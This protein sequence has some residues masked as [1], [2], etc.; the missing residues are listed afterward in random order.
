MALDLRDAAIDA[1]I[2]ARCVVALPLL[3]QTRDAGLDPLVLVGFALPGQ[4]GPNRLHD[5]VV[6]RLQLRVIVLDG[7][8]E[9]AEVGVRVVV[10]QLVVDL[11]DRQV[12]QTDVGRLQRHHRLLVGAVELRVEVG[13]QRL[14]LLIEP[15]RVLD[16]GGHHDLVRRVGQGVGKVVQVDLQAQI[17][18]GEA[19]LRSLLDVAEAELPVI[20]RGHLARGRQPGD[21]GLAENLAHHVGVE[22]IAA[23]IGQHRLDA[24]QALLHDRIGCDHRHRSLGSIHGNRRR[25]GHGRGQRGVRALLSIRAGLVEDRIVGGQFIVVA[26]IGLAAIAEEVGL[27]PVGLTGIAGAIFGTLAEIVAVAIVI[28]GIKGPRLLQVRGA[29]I[30]AGIRRGSAQRLTGVIAEAR[31]RQ[32]REGLHQIGDQGLL[33]RVIALGQAL[34]QAGHVHLAGFGQTGRAVGAVVDLVV[35]VP[36]DLAHRADQR[37]GNDLFELDDPLGHAHGV[38]EEIL[39]QTA[40]LD[41]D[42]GLARRDLEDLQATGL[43]VL[44]DHAPGVRRLDEDLVLLHARQGIGVGDDR[45]HILV[46]EL[47]VDDRL[48]V[49]GD[50]RRDERALVLLVAAPGLLAQAAELAAGRQDQ[51]DVGVGVEFDVAVGVEDL[52]GIG[53]DERHIVTQRVDGRARL[54]LAEHGAQALLRAE[55]LGRGGRRGFRRNARGDDLVDLAGVRADGLPVGRIGR[56]IRL[57]ERIAHGCSYLARRGGFFR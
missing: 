1:P 34:D 54:G 30:G 15:G 7:L 39:V 40:L 5:L 11:L 53:H 46:E 13:D 29:V 42:R 47:R 38:I 2:P 4:G 37:E 36:E 10:V 45:Q 41:V 57:L 43:G 51:H 21:I 14:E 55:L 33:G 23:Q 50:H 18:V 6:L 35:A 8:V 26:E 17:L 48:D 19:D 3:A 27:D 32:H 9:L 31:H 44:H 12:G 25:I 52:H 49:V 56:L 22:L 24:G 16:A 20:G 28:N